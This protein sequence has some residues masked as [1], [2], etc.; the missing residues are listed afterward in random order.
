VSDLDVS[1]LA[2]SDAAVALRSFPRRYRAA[3]Q[4]VKDDDDV[5]E[6]AH[7]VGPDGRSAI[8]IL[9]DVTRTLVVLA[10][11][12]RQITVNDTPVVHAAVVD[13]ALRHWDAPPPERLDD[14]L[15]I[16]DDEAT[17]LADAV[18]RVP[19]DAWTRSGSVA[20]GGSVTALTVVRDAVRDGRQGLEEIVRT[21]AAVRD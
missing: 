19:V 3:I 8:Q 5:E 15:V 10:D 17:S 9:S 7:R 21:L 18:D 14:A 4:P 20:G 6:L 11:A 12:L 1:R 13:P 2:P 16:F